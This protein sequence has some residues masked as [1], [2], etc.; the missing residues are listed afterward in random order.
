ML[1]RLDG[2]IAVDTHSQPKPAVFRLSE[3]PI[4]GLAEGLVGARTNGVRKLIIPPEL[5]YGAAGLPGQV[6]PDA[7]VV[8]DVT[9]I[10][11]R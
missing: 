2:Q 4:K 5:A 10:E 9:I 1:L 3:A 8:M 7:T 11:V 6:P